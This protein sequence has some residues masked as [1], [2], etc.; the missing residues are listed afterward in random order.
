ML[1]FQVPMELS[2]HKAAKVLANAKTMVM[3]LSELS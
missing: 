2:A 3:L 1:T